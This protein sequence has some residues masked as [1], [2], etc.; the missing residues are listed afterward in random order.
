MWD[1]M[2][3]LIFMALGGLLVHFS[4]LHAWI[5]YKNGKNEGRGQVTT[6]GNRRA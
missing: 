2:W 6:T 4:W 3:A 5:M 1:I